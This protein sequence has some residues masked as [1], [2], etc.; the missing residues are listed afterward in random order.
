MKQDSQGKQGDD[1]DNNSPRPR[2]LPLLT[3]LG[4]LVAGGALLSIIAITAAAAVP[5]NVGKALAAQRRLVAERPEDAAAWNDLGNL[6]VLAGQPSEAEAAYRRATAIDPHRASALYNL[7]LLLQQEAKPSEARQLYEKV[8]EIEPQHAWAHYQLGTL[9]E[10]KGDKSRA[11]REYAQAFAL[12]PQLAFREVNPEIVENGL[13]TESLLLAYRRHT[14]AA[15]APSVYDEPGRIRELMLPAQPGKEAVAEAR[16]G[17]PPAGQAAPPGGRPTVLRPGNLPPG[18][19]VGQATPPGSHPGGPAG[20][21]RPPGYAAPNYL[22]Q[23]SGPYQANRQWTR[24]NPVVPNPNMDGTQPG[25]VV[26]PP[27]ATLYYRPS[28][29][30]TGRLGTQIVPEQNG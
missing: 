23:D 16:P 14:A 18:G 30:S 20:A 29:N 12:D 26:T 3:A 13:V 19:N 11:V 10:R 17:E 28:P 25:M 21:A 6:L 22:Q 2:A 27:P 8:L 7:G 1:V 9:H 4:A 15:E 5:P 24:P